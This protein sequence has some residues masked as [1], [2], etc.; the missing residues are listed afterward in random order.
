MKKGHQQVTTQLI[1]VDYL[2]ISFTVELPG[3]QINP[4]TFNLNAN[5]YLEFTPNSCKYFSTICNLIIDGRIIGE[6]K[7]NPSTPYIDQNTVHFKVSN[8]LLYTVDY[9]DYIDYIIEVLGFKYNHIVRLD[10]CIDCTEHNLL[11]FINKYFNSSKIR[12]KGRNKK[13][14]R[15]TSGKE[16]NTVYVGSINSEK[17]LKIYD[18]TLEL[19]KSDKEYIKHY[20]AL[21]GLDYKNRSVERLELTLKTKHAKFIQYEKLIDSDYLASIIRTHFKNFFEFEGKYKENGKMVKKDVTPIKLCNYKTVLLQKYTYIPRC[22][23]VAQKI[24]LRRLFLNICVEKE[25]IRVEKQNVYK[26]QQHYD[27]LSTYYKAVDNFRHAI[28]RIIT[29]YD[30][31]GYFKSK[32]H[33]W[34]KEFENNRNEYINRININEKKEENFFI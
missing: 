25:L 8:H 19:Q 28:K 7:F 10:T 27:N 16:I 21:N 11:G 13:I 30:L 29:L 15:V 5:C 34:E 18:K 33:H 3:W 32:K 17:Y 1:N 14:T 4:K 23:I 9:V 12:L 31:H 26:S 22:S 20:Y 24:E 6:L 2:E